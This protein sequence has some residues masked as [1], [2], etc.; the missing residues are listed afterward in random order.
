MTKSLRKMIMNRSRCKNALYKNRT[1]ENWEKYRKFRN[2]CVKLTKKVKREYF[3]NLSL[4]S[5]TDNKKFWKSV[6]PN[7]TN[8]T[9]KNEKIILV[10]NENIISENKEI[11]EIMN[12]YFVN[13]TKELNIPEETLCDA[14]SL[15]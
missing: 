7:F 3:E 6:K 10:E 15:F 12:D 5:I 11:A 4:N 2:D 1:A 8:K 13:I 14:D 9:K